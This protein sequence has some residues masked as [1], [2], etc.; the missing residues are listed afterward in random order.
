MPKNFGNA[1]LKDHVSKNAPGAFKAMA[2][3]CGVSL[4]VFMA[5]CKGDQKAIQFISDMGRLAATTKE[6]LPQALSA[7]KLV[8]EA[9]GDLNKALAELAKQTR[10][11]GTQIINSVYSATND[12]TRMKNEIVEMRDK[13]VNDVTAETGRHLRK[14]NL[15][16][17]EGATAELMAVTDY[18][19]SKQKAEDKI[20]VAQ[21]RADE[22]YERAVNTA[23]WA[24][25]SDA[26][27]SRIR[28]PNYERNRYGLGG[29]W[30]GFKNA[31]G[32]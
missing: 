27:L 25:G 16:A 24:R 9:T 31:M 28:K 5:A 15:I 32:L 12:E 1:V 22:A 14:R 30:Q 4:E 11:S 21:Q 19:V 29:L 23:L 26:D 6:N 3:L 13:Q 7:T 8:I 2:E 10:T 18:Q 20:P 17:I